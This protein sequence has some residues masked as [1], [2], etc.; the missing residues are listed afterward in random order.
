MSI[1]DKNNEMIR[2]FVAP[3]R[4]DIDYYAPYEVHTALMEE[5]LDAFL[6]TF[7]D[8]VPNIWI[9]T[10]FTFSTSTVLVNGIETDV[11]SLTTWHPNWYIL[12]ILDRVLASR[13]KRQDLRT[14]MAEKL[15]SALD[16]LMF[17][18]DVRPILNYYWLEDPSQVLIKLTFEYERVLS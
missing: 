5:H 12:L 10:D 1:L 16:D 18:P 3:N 14:M 17:D 2:L 11:E 6:D 15:E 8:L 13:L 7:T 4:V 9:H